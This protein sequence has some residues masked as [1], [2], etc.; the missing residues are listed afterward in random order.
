MGDSSLGVV[1]HYPRRLAAATAVLALALGGTACGSDHPKDGR[2]DP[3]SRES[4]AK[5]GKSGTGELRKQLPPLTKRFDALGSPQSATWM[6][7]TMGDSD[8]PGP[9]TYWIDAVVTLAPGEARALRARYAAT[10][11]EAAPDV[12]DELSGKVPH[13]GLLASDALDRAFSQAGFVTKAF[14]DVESNRVVLTAKGQ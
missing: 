4:E 2:S 13:H 12:V 9:S 7:G 10:E 1:R 3:V 8:V 11:A 14:L 6:S 5:A